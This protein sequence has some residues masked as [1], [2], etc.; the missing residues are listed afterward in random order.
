MKTKLLNVLLTTALTFVG[1]FVIA[2]H[3][4]E[5]QHNQTVEIAQADDY[6]SSINDSLTGSSLLSALNTLNE[7]KRTKTMGYGTM[8]SYFQYTDTDSTANGKIVGFYNNA[9]VGPSWDS[10]NTWN[11]EH[12]WPKSRNGSAVEG[13]AHMVRPTATSINSERGNMFYG[14]VSG[15]YDPGQYIAEYRG[16]AA[17]I[18]FY[19]AIADTNLS[20]VDLSDDSASNGTMG[21]LSELLKWNLQYAPDTSSTASLALRVEQNRNEVIY[22]RS[23]MQ[24]NRNPFIDHPEYACK[25]WGD[26]NDAT[27]AICANAQ[28]DPVVINTNEVSLEIGESFDLVATTIDES[29]VEWVFE[30]NAYSILNFQDTVTESGKPLN[31][32]A[33]KNG[34]TTITATSSNGG[35]ATCVVT[36]GTG[37]S[38]DDDSDTKRTNKLPLI[39]GI[40]LGVGIPLVPVAVVLIILI[41]KR[42]RS[43]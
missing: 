5:N 27:K 3:S 43:L 35:T 9:L 8:R 10:G 20:L 33:L 36:C 30:D 13:D 17:R 7:S 37:V 11:R 31:I 29:N 19:C 42:K 21:K 25:I 14:T 4:S 18:I 41:V 23:D 12:V 16:I 39:L 1:F 38:D 34:T 28:T 24:G 40:S 26:T 2:K 6:Y 22:S 32:K 15:T